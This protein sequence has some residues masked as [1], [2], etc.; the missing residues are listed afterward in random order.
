VRSVDYDGDGDMDLFTGVRLKPFAYGYPCKGYILQNDGKGNFKDVTEQ[1]AP[2]LKTAGMITDAQWFDYDKDGKPDLVIT[3]EYMPIRIFKNEKINNQTKLKEITKEAGLENTSGWWNRLIV[4][5]INGDN[6]PDIIGANHGQNSRFKATEKRPVEMWVSDFDNNGTIEQVVTC[7]N[8]DSSYPM[9]LR[10]DLV[11]ALP[12]LKK[13]YLK[14]EDYKNETIGDVFTEQQLRQ[15]VHLE[16]KEMR[17]SVLLN[18]KNGTFTLKPLP[19]EAQL[20]QLYGIAVIDYDKDGKEDIVMG[21]NFYESRPEAGIYDGT[22]G[23]LLKGDGTGN[24]TAI[25]N[26]QSGINIRGAVRD[27]ITLHVGKKKKLL[28][29][30]LNNGP[31]SIFNEN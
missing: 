17:S 16:A 27:I 25:P 28:L 11:N 6:Y 26:Q 7:Y 30:T 10:H 9:A 21:G 19:K 12:Y 22:Y 15:A 13:K 8:G 31:L 3:G 23:L 4:A 18:N 24:F 1:T 29:W 5:D 2:E 20:S 14:Y